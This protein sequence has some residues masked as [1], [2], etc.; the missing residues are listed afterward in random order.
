MFR[1]AQ[2]PGRFF[3]KTGVIR[4]MNPGSPA[5]ALPHSS[6]VMIPAG[7]EETN[8]CP[9]L[10]K[11]FHSN[12]LRSR[13]KWFAPEYY[14]GVFTVSYWKPQSALYFFFSLLLFKA[15]GSE[16]EQSAVTP[17]EIY[18]DLE[19]IQMEKGGLCQ[20]CGTVLTALSGLR[21]PH[22]AVSERKNWETPG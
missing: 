7:T 15:D 3:V 2:F 8:W 17:A 16:S 12:A 21:M 18:E 11:R 13:C 20:P 4:E 22:L 10:P 9:S 19:N 5:D 14:L 6:S 1:E